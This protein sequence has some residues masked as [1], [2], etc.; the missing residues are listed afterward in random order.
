MEG[1]SYAT[2]EQQCKDN[3]RFAHFMAVTTEALVKDARKNV[4][5]YSKQNGEKLEQIVLDKMRSLASEFD[6]SPEKI[7]KSDR[8]HFPDIL[9][10]DTTYG[11]EVKSVKDKTWT[12]TGSSIVE[13]LRESEIEKVFLMFGRLSAPEIDFRCKPYEDCLSEIA[14]THSPRYLINMDM[15]ATDKTIFEKMGTSY[16]QFRKMGDGQINLVRKHYR[17]KFRGRNQKSMPWWISEEPTTITHPSELYNPSCE[18]RMLSDLSNEVKEY[19][20]VCSYALFPEILG[21]DQDKFRK[22]SLWI[23]SR[24]SIICSNVRDFFTAGGTVNIYVNDKLEWENVP[25]V[26]ANLALYIHNIK[27]YLDSDE[28]LINDVNNFSSFNNGDHLLFSQW[29][30]TADYYISTTLS[31]SDGYKSISKRKLNVRNLLSIRKD[32][33]KNINKKDCYFLTDF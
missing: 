22:P 13:T 16:E 31:K 20:R 25:K 32:Y 30:K 28:E 15:S 2:V 18:F 7:R 12:S 4:A 26:V 9:L 29:E 19:F 24:F 27:R 17:E 3:E 8:Q 33:I 1:T 23:C 14:V 6:I 5:L 11:V 10:D 21:T